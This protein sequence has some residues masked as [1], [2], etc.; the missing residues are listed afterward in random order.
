DSQR[1]TTAWLEAVP[2][3][4]RVDASLATAKEDQPRDCRWLHGELIDCIQERRPTSATSPGRRQTAGLNPTFRRTNSDP[5]P[6]EHLSTPT[7]R[8]VGRGYLATILMELAEIAA[9]QNGRRIEGVHGLSEEMA[10]AF[11]AEGFFQVNLSIRT[12]LSH[13]NNRRWRMSPGVCP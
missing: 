5:P 13:R 4:A 6:A 8:V 2:Y 10:S 1:P 9:G 12:S 7:S 3:L 11:R